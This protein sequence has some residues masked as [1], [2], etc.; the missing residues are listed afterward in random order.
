MRV[1]ES[2]Q[3]HGSFPLS[4][5]RW[6]VERSRREARSLSDTTASF[7]QA[8]RFQCGWK[9][10]IKEFKIDCAED[11]DFLSTAMIVPNLSVESLSCKDSVR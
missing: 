3:H 6:D 5:I 7:L 1:R 11:K 2:L 10:H 4:L 8:S 9:D